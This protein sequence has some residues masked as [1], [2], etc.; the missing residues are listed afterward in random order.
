MQFLAH[1]GARVVDEDVY[2]AE[3]LRDVPRQRLYL[4]L[5]AHV[6]AVG[7]AFSSRR[8]HERESVG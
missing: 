7:F 8:S 1:G 3:A 2:C 5:F 4:R 6:A